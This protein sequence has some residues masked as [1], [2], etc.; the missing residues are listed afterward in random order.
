MGEVRLVCFWISAG[1]QNVEVAVTVDVAPTGEAD[2]LSTDLRKKYGAKIL[3]LTFCEQQKTSRRYP[4]PCVRRSH[5]LSMEST[6][7][8]ISAF[9]PV[10][11]GPSMNQQK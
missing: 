5:Y 4:Y 10:S 8:I 11:R 6:R 7:R 9:L 3:T 1:N 2:A